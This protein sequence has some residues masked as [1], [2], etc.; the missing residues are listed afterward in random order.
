MT[1]INLMRDADG[2]DDTN[3]N[4]NNNNDND[5]SREFV[6]TPV[7]LE[8]RTRVGGGFVLQWLTPECRAHRAHRAHRAGA[9]ATAPFGPKYIWA[10]RAD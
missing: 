5:N 6:L 8:T 1:F 3:I 2:N 9:I 10:D 7:I 4:N